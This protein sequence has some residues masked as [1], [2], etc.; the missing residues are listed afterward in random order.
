MQ[1]KLFLRQVKSLKSNLIFHSKLGPIMRNPQT[2]I[3]RDCPLKLIIAAFNNWLTHQ[4]CV[5]F[6]YIYEKLFGDV[7]K[8][9]ELYDWGDQLYPSFEREHSCMF[10]SDFMVEFCENLWSVCKNSTNSN[11]NVHFLRS[12]EMTKI[13]Q[14][15]ICRKCVPFWDIHNKFQNEIHDLS[16]RMRIVYI[17]KNCHTFTTELCQRIDSSD[18]FDAEKKKEIIEEIERIKNDN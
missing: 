17:K 12:D 8:S 15:V 9:K 16:D 2:V 10:T 4:G 6:G 5:Y 3:S 11:D 14:S 1:G 7:V 18:M 13:I